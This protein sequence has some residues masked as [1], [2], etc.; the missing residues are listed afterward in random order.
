MNQDIWIIFG[1]M[2]ILL[3]SFHFFQATQI[4]KKPNNKAGIDSI[5]GIKLGISEFIHDF[6]FYV[7]DLNKQN[8]IINILTAIGYLFASVTA[9]YSY[10]LSIS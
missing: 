5:E 2:F 9:F 7:D 3:S 10:Y 6:G 8:K 4:I 1:I